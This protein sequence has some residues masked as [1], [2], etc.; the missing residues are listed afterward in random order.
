MSKTKF[1]VYVKHLKVLVSKINV[2][3]TDNEILPVIEQF[4]WTLK[5]IFSCSLGGIV[6][7]VISDNYLYL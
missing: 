2:N 4:L 6:F 5:F 7:S 1:E 3:E